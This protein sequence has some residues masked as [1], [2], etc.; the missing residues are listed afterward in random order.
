MPSVPVRRMLHLEKPTTRWFQA[1]FYEAPL[2]V[3]MSAFANLAR[4]YARDIRI[5]SRLAQRA[6]AIG[7]DA[8]GRQAFRSLAC[9]LV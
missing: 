1:V 3:A 4:C 6:L 2:A 9:E 8:R 7:S 5:I